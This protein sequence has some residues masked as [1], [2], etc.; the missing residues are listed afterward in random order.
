MSR[1]TRL[2]QVAVIRQR[3]H[4]QR[5]AGRRQL[6]LVLR[7]PTV[8]RH[9]CVI[10]A[11]PEGFLLR[12]LGSTNGTRLAGY[13]VGSA[14]LEGGASIGVGETKLRFDLSGEEV[15]EPLS[16]DD[17]YGRMLGR[18]PAMRRIFALL[19]RVAA[20]DATVL[21][22]GET[23]TGKGLL[24]EMLHAESPRKGGPFVTV[25]CGSIPPTLIGS[26]LFGHTRGAFTGAVAPKVGA[27][28]A[29]QGGTVFLDEVGEL[30]LE[31]QPQLLRVLEERTVKRL[32]SVEPLKLDVRVIAATNVDLRQAVNRGSFRSDLFYR[33]DV[34]RIVV[35]PLRERREDIAALVAHFYEQQARDGETPPPAVVAALSAHDWPGNVR[36]LRSAVE[37]TLLLGD[38]QLWNEIST[39]GVDVPP[40]AETFDPALS[41]RAAKERAV[42]RWEKWYVGKLFDHAQRNLSRAA[43][44]AHMDRTHLREMLRRYGHSSDEG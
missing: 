39:G 22:E 29:A 16:P 12:D 34:V 17:R 5:S 33:L 23:G 11:T 28:A 42:A 38:P 8:S 44:T 32:G 27:F 2:A 24:A 15:G 10:A 6:Q 37:R 19:P 20:S 36:E 30:P 25:D 9:H 26:E 21:L 1:E 7:D 4:V 43:R 3:E 31:M 14:W 13:R 35:P 18:S 41:F 40:G